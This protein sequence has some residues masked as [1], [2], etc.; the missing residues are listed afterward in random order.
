[1]A[2]RTAKTSW[3]QFLL[4]FFVSLIIVVGAFVVAAPFIEF[5]GVVVP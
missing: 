5:G 4:R 3:G 2:R 1:M